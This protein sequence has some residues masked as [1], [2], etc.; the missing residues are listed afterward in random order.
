MSLP[1]LSIRLIP[2]LIF[3]AAG[4]AALNVIHNIKE[5]PLGQRLE[6]RK[7]TVEYTLKELSQ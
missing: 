3:L 2:I 1:L 6:Q 5:S 4:C 7:H